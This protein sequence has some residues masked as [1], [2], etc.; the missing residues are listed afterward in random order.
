MV[1]ARPTTV[2]SREARRRAIQSSIITKALQAQRGWIRALVAL[3][4]TSLAITGLTIATIKSVF[5]DAIVAR[6]AKLGD[7]VA[8]LVLLAIVGF[9]ISLGVRLVGARVVYQLELDMRCWLYDKL[10]AVDP[11]SL[12]KLAAGQLVTRSLTDLNF[13]EQLTAVLPVVLVGGVVLV[14]VA[15]VM[16]AI[17]PVMGLIMLVAF[18]ANALIVGRMAKRLRAMS[19]LSLHRRAVVTTA[20]DEPVRGIRVVKAFAVETTQRRRVAE[21]AQGAYAVAMAR[22]RL[23][24]RFGI[25]VKIIP[26]LLDAIL[27]V[28]GAHLGVDGTFTIGALVVYLGFAI[29]L[30]AFAGQLD[31]VVSAFQFARTGSGR[32]FE[33][34]AEPDA[35]PAPTATLPPE[36]S[37]LV[38]DAAA[39]DHGPRAGLMVTPGG[40]VGLTGPPG[41]G[42]SAVGRMAVGAQ[43]VV[44]GTVT[45]DGVALG[46]ISRDELRRSARLV[47]SEPFLFGRTVRENLLVGALGE[48]VADPALDAALAA[49]AADGF[50]AE[51]GGLDAAVGDRGLTLSGGQRQRL[52]LARAIVVPPRL[53]VLDDA[54]SAVNAELEVTILAAVRR[55][56]P[57][58][59]VLL[60]TRRP[61]PLSVC[62]SVVE[63]PD[64][65]VVEDDAADEDD[66]DETTFERPRDPDLAAAVDAL[67]FPET[68]PNVP[69]AAA[70]DDSRPP[71]VPNVLRPARWWL[72][73][74]VGLLALTS[75]VALAPSAMFQIAV[76]GIHEHDVG[77][78]VRVGL[79]LVPLALVLGLLTYPLRVVITRVSESVLYILRRRAFQRLSRLGVD[80]YD[81]ELPGRVASRIVYDLDRITEFVSGGVFLL[82]QSVFLFL[83]AGAVLAIVS[84]EAFVAVAP[85]FPLMIVGTLIELPLAER[86]YRRARTRLGLVVE[87]FHEDFSGRHVIAA[88]G[89][90]D[91]ARAEF[92]SLSW[93]LRIARRRSAT[94]ANIY[95]AAMEALAALATAVLIAKAGGLAIEQQA[96]IGSV[97][98]LQ[99]LLTQALAPIPALSGVLQSYLNARASFRELGQPFTEPVL[100]VERAD[101]GPCPPLAGALALDGVTFTYPGTERQVLG[102]VTLHIEPGEIIALVGPTGAGKSSI[103]KLLARVYDPDVGAVRVDGTDVRDLDL[104]SYRRRLG[105]V[106]QD[107]FCFRGTV[108]SNIAF[109]R[110]EAE[111]AELTGALTACGGLDLLDALPAGLDTEVQE[112]G[113]NL[114]PVSRQWVALARAWLVAPDVLVL[115]EATSSLTTAAEERVLDA[116]RALGRTAVV[117]THRIEV[118]ARADRVVVVEGGAI[119]EQGPHAE[120]LVRSERY[121]QLWAHGITV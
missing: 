114:S 2:S 121:R 27:I 35:A 51:L 57:A 11:R 1:L 72:A 80:Y 55:H 52:A 70:V 93:D 16:I 92:R 64:P 73:A 116:L 60:V 69:E 3:S 33:L 101:A 119:A 26:L 81:R 71:T 44:H 91:Q 12:D 9:G 103:A 85:F 36:A 39:S 99:L 56:A 83:I 49:A 111:R 79:L 113:R 98:F 95:L 6:T 40:W 53:L 5:D 107:A 28:I 89:G 120:V 63:L 54:L 65:I 50:V 115:D 22:I 14:A 87:R 42:S 104:G 29:F 97:V 96:S 10:Q 90:Q 19:W 105:V 32:I 15:I 45:L 67:R 58:T 31:E 118:A 48:P 7:L 68:G 34:M 102:D 38:L 24:A 84:P 76:N 59:A 77:P 4:A 88:Y 30:T 20:I 117:V 25:P 37:G 18:P 109:G 66:A 46:E 13:L 82:A 62:D 41:A 17:N 106:P 78:A 86:A 47:E 43:P 94:V 108:A 75:V 8:F 23:L 61:G 112:E 21:A 110:P 74:A 100:P